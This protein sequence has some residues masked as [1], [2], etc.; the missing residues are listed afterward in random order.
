MTYEDIDEELSEF[1]GEV[2]FVNILNQYVWCETT[3]KVVGYHEQSKKGYELAVK[4]TVPIDLSK[5]T[6]LKYIEKEGITEEDV[7]VFCINQDYYP[8]E[9]GN[10]VLLDVIKKVHKKKLE[11]KRKEDE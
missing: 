6:L 7:L 9:K 11:N 3:K 5:T 2:Y 10:W 8:K 1:P 4:T